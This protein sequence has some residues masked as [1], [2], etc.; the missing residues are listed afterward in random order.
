MEEQFIDAENKIII[1]CPQC[2]NQEAV[3]LIRANRLI[4]GLQASRCDACKTYYVINIATE[5]TCE[6][7]VYK[8]ESTA[9]AGDSP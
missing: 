4:N 7:E 5:I 6:A 9:P 1:D 3:Y 8:C 2:G